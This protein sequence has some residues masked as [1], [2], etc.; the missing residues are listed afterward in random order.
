[1]SVNTIPNPIKK[2]ILSAGI[3]VFNTDIKKIE[4]TVNSLIRST[5]PIEIII[6]CNSPDVAYQAK[7]KD[8]FSNHGLKLLTNQPNRGFGQGHNDL[9]SQITTD[10]YVC[11]NPDIH[12]N[13]DAIEVLYT[14]AQELPDAVQLMPKILNEDGS[15]QMLCRRYLSLFTW[16]HRQLWRV[17]PSMFRPYEM[18]FNYDLFGQIE[19]VSGAFFLVSKR[20]FLLLK[21]FDPD[22]FLYCEDADLSMRASKIG[23]NYYVPQAIVIHSWS[24]AWTHSKHMIIQELKSLW[25]YFKKHKK[26]L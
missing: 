22:F 25:K 20:N 11:C 5:I 13:P 21:G 17:F 10:W 8:I 12:V 15:I 4:S 26:L 14:K 6:L 18:I 7:I 19:F 2:P 16:V 23:N 9:V 1:M 3:V 24:K